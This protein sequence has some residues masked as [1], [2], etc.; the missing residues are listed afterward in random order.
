MCE[1]FKKVMQKKKQEDQFQTSLFFKK[2]IYEV[3]ASGVHIY[4]DNPQTWTYRDNKP[5]KALDCWSRNM[6]NFDFVEKGR[7]LVSAPHF[8]YNFSK[9][10]F[11]F[12]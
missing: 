2:A 10:M 6:F 12:Y 3:E 5:Y 8:A 9:K 4:F 7:G 1:I 11:M